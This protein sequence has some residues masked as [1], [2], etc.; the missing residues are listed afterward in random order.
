MQNNIAKNICFCALVWAVSNA[1]FISEA[2]AQSSQ[3][4]AN[5]NTTIG[6]NS[7]F[8]TV[9]QT[10]NQ[11]NAQNQVNFSNILPLNNPI[12][13]PVN[14][15]NDLGLNFSLAVN[16]LDS[17]NVTLFLGLIYQPG[18]T[19]DHKARMRRLRAETAVLESQKQISQ[20]QLQLLQK[21]IA[22][23][24]YRLQNLKR[25]PTEAPSPGT[26]GGENR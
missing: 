18:R 22:E 9:V 10:P 7:E 8:N 11:N 12:Y 6:N 3:Q 1:A 25:S 24:E 21:Q 14:T 16:T 17:S 20:A 15:E 2:I 23:A 5:P 13:T 26:N 4:N 19:E